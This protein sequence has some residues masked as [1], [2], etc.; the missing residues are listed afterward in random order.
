MQ[1]SCNLA[2]E[3]RCLQARQAEVH[4]MERELADHQRSVQQLAREIEQLNGEINKA[5]EEKLQLRDY[6]KTW[7]TGFW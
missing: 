1:L 5:E 4:E 2:R 7:T 3:Q 6:E